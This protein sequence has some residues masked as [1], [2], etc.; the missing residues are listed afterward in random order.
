MKK[1]LILVYVILAAVSF[2]S[3]RVVV[4]EEFTRVSG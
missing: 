4:M 1:S 3:Q 2:A